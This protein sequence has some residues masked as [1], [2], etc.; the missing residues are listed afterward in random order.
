MSVLRYWETRDTHELALILIQFFITSA[1]SRTRRL[2]RLGTFMTA[3]LT[4][5]RRPYRPSRQFRHPDL[6]NVVCRDVPVPL[7]K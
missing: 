7:R 3:T 1:S 6:V 5:E 2:T 4:S